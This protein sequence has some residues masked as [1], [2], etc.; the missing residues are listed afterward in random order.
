MRYD[1]AEKVA[2]WC[3]WQ[4]LFLGGSA[5]GFVFSRGRLVP[6]FLFGVA[7]FGFFSGTG[8]GALFIFHLDFLSG[9]F[10]F[11][12]STFFFA[13]SASGPV[14]LSVRARCLF[15]Q[16]WLLHAHRLNGTCKVHM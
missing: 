15:G 14:L 12:F 4:F 3:G 11:S 1:T 13:F 10:L 5:G 8:G 6:C 16:P 2:L 9:G 7:C